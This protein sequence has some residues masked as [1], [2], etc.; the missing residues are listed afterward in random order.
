MVQN[1]WDAANTVLRG[2][3]KVIQAYLKKQEKSQPNLT[4]NRPGKQRA[5]ETKGQ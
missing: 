5:N 4:F 3:F 2:K 1:L